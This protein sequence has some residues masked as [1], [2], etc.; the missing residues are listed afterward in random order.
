MQVHFRLLP[1]RTSWRMVNLSC[2]II[3][4]HV[5]SWQAK[6]W[7]HSLGGEQ[8]LM[9]FVDLDS[10][11]LDLPKGKGLNGHT[12]LNFEPPLVVYHFWQTHFWHSIERHRH[13]LT[14][15]MCRPCDSSRKWHRKLNHLVRPVNLPQTISR[16]QVSNPSV[17]KPHA[18][19]SSNHYGVCVRVFPPSSL[20]C[21][22]VCSMAVNCS[23]RW[24][25]AR[26]WQCVLSRCGIKCWSLTLTWLTCPAWA[27]FASPST[28]SLRKPRNPEAPKRRIRKQWV[29]QK[30]MA[31][32]GL[33]VQLGY[34]SWRM[35]GLV[36][37]NC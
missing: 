37:V 23:V 33:G 11:Y 28:P 13:P 16:T 24:W 25:R 12:I 6:V 4:N 29:H 5:C 31:F 17:R 20:W 1:Q 30:L 9:Y 14:I 26:R 34:L 3:I 8:P 2:H 19:P 21:R 27:A 7:K 15:W 35:F 36:G 18:M 10:D 32:L 22:P